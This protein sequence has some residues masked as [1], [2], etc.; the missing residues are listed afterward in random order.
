MLKEYRPVSKE[1]T[2]KDYPGKDN[3]ETPLSVLAYLRET[4]NR[5]TDLIHVLADL[6]DGIE[7]PTTKGAGSN[8]PK[9]EGNKDMMT[10][11]RECCELSEV[12]QMGSREISR[13][14]GG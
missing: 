7:N 2:T 11:A 13:L 10:L 3:P 1:E 9:A 14:L 5:L 6:R 12:L 4:H 8:P